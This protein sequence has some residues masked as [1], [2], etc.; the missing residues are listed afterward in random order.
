MLW[1]RGSAFFRFLFLPPIYG[2]FVY[3]V[4]PRWALGVNGIRC[5][6]SPGNPRG[7]KERYGMVN[8]GITN[9]IWSF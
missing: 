1:I 5:G 6:P 8:G 9:K 7:P 3:L 4:T 2:G